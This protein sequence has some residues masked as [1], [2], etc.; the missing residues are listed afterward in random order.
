MTGYAISVAGFNFEWNIKGG[1]YVNI[2]N[3]GALYCFA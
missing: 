2:N 3:V 1:F